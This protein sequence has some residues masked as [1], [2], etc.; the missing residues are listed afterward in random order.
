MTEIDICCLIKHNW[1]GRKLQSI[2]AT[3]SFQVSFYLHINVKK[4]A[5]YYQ[6]GKGK[7]VGTVGH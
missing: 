6:C 7:E 2:P 4:C 5:C 3:D 1:I